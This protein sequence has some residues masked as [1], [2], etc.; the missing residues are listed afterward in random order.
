[1]VLAH[2]RPVRAGRG[3]YKPWIEELEKK[4]KLPIWKDRKGTG[5]VKPRQLLRCLNLGY[6]HT[7]ILT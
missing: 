4:A 1:M 6:G 7:G 5:K 3:G 2:G